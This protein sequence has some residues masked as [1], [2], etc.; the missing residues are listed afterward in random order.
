MLFLFFQVLCHLVSDVTSDDLG[1]WKGKD[2]NAARLI[3][4]VPQ[5][6]LGVIIGSSI[7]WSENGVDF[8]PQV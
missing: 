6:A 5:S 1:D 4:I 2:V 3:T 8:A 7:A